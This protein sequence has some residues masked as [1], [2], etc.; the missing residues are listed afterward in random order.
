[1]TKALRICEPARD[2]PVG[3]EEI[4]VRGFQ[5]D[6]GGEMLELIV[7]R[8][9]NDLTVF[10]NACPHT[11]VVL[12]WLPDQFLDVEGVLLQCATHGALFD[13]RNGN[14]LRGPCVG[15]ALHRLPAR[16][17]EGVLYLED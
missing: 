9:G 17:E 2:L 14:C 8:H 13:P 15:Q 7:V 16:L 10:K 3:G 1:M 5:V 4:V 11:G 12:N 6:T